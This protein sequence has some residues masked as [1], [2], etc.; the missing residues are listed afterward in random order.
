MDNKLTPGQAAK[1][2]AKE[3]PDFEGVLA[4][5][6]LTRKGRGGWGITNKTTRFVVSGGRA[7]AIRDDRKAGTFNGVCHMCSK[8][9]LKCELTIAYGRDDR[10]GQLIPEEELDAAEPAGW[11]R[12]HYTLVYGRWANWGHLCPGCIQANDLLPQ[13]EIDYSQYAVGKFRKVR[14]N[15]PQRPTATFQ[16]E[17][18]DIR[19]SQ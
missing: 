3:H 9:F 11:M 19:D 16:T 15:H 6:S 14:M 4:V 7:A 17:Y 8:V 10:D 2:W 5:E 18:L 1:K 13:T 12:R